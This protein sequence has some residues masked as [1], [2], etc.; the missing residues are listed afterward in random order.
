[1][2][3]GTNGAVLRTIDDGKTWTTCTVPPDADHLDFRG[4]QAFDADTAIVMS[5]GKG[6][7]SRL[8]KTTDGCKTWKLVFTNPE[9]DGFWD[10]VRITSAKTALLIGDPIPHTQ[11]DRFV[12]KTIFHFPLYGSV[13]GGDTWTRLDSNNLFALSDGHGKPAQFIF[14]ASNSS[15]IEI[16][17]HNLIVF[18]EGGEIASLGLLEMIDH[19]VST[20]CKTSCTMAGGSNVPLK[21][22]PTAGAF[23]IAAKD[24]D[25]TDP[26]LV[27]VGGDFAKPDDQAGTAAGCTRNSNLLIAT[28]FVC[29]APQTPPH[30]YRS[31]VA[32]DDA[33]K[34]WI[35]VGPNG[36]DV[37]TDDGR[38][39][40]AVH[41]DA[42][43]NE[44]TDAD[45]NWNALSLPFVVGPHGRIG[46][47]DP[48]ALNDGK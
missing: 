7:L 12:L 19:P 6:D 31:A 30:G 45:R 16:A 15:L 29:E 1:M 18:A 2:G 44:Q 47:L 27:V 17:R 32:Y 43:I 33:T 42:A 5:S 4:V 8:Y 25:P 11:L 39:W 38:N 23:S 40:R 34:I 22:G 41:P 3:V 26:M 9:K 35:T 28:T 13:D 48:A 21:G 14:A 20:I 36:T 46:K 37:S 10:A 24:P